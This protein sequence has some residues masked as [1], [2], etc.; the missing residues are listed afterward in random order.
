MGRIKRTFD[1][2]FKIKVCEAIDS[3]E[4]TVL[5]VCR[6]HQ[7]QRPVVEAWFQ[8]FVRGELEGKKLE[9]AE[10]AQSRE[11]EKLKAKVGELTMQMDALK[12]FYQE[13]KLPLK[14]ER[15]PIHTGSSLGVKN[16]Q[17]RPGIYLPAPSITG[18]KVKR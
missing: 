14:N 15:S 13:K 5:E 6:Q 8:K 9:S 2:G 3:G 18:K 11:I 1:I 12:K 7:I 4:Q 16:E 10:S 17:L